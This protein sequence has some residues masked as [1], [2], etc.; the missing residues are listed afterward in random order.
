MIACTII[1]ILTL[2]RSSTR[3]GSTS[4]RR[5]RRRRNISVMLITI[6]LV[7]INLTAPI[8]VFLTVYPNVRDKSKH[9]RQVILILIKV[10]CIILMNLNHSVNIIIYSVT[11]REF[12]SEMN[13][14]LHAILYFFIG[15]PINPNN[16]A[17]VQDDRTIISR[18]RQNLFNCCR[19]KLNSNSTST[20]D[21]GD[22][23]HIKATST[24]RIS[25]TNDRT[26][27]NISKKR[28]DFD[29]K[30]KK[31]LS[32]IGYK[33]I[34]RAQKTDHHLAVRLR[35]GAGSSVFEREDI[36]VQDFSYSTEL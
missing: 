22:L 6:N 33:E 31:H 24:N 32:F 29:Q 25:S 8:V 35:D 20:I 23:L 28:K 7:F 3:A 10:I 18:L 17:Y 13:N 9:R 12:R 27:E 34:S 16:Y 4:V 11:A 36:S 1:I 30:D 21:S 5:S 26:H 14:L 2:V 19:I 15:K